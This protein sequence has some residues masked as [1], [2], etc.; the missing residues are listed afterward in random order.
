MILPNSRE[1]AQSTA[2]FGNNAKLH[3]A[4][5]PM[6]ARFVSL[7]LDGPC[8]SLRVRRD[9]SPDGR[10]GMSPF[11]PSAFFAKS[12]K[13][14][15]RQ[16]FAGFS[17]DTRKGWRRA[18]LS[19][20][21]AGCETPILQED[22]PCKRFGPLQRFSRF[23]CVLPVATHWANRP[24][25]GQVP[26]ALS[27]LSPTVIPSPVQPSV[28]PQTSPIAAATHRAADPLSRTVTR[29]RTVGANRPGGPFSCLA[30]AAAP[31]ARP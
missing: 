28:W 23:A 20:V 11:R 3:F 16:R 2:H 30:V 27:R 12:G 22:N 18:A 15:Y 26:A 25:S 31:G 14:D 19:W 10:L 4:D 7:R 17:S 6:P 29:F 21:K 24:L 1:I 5:A 13:T 9:P 8:G